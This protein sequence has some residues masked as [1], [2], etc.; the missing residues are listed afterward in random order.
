[1]SQT[2]TFGHHRWTEMLTSVNFMKI[3]MNLKEKYINVLRSIFRSK[4]SLT[5]FFC[6]VQCL[7]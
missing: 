4:K 7:T 6:N 2:D 1:M 3:S 5:V